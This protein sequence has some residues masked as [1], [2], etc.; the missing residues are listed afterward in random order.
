MIEEKLARSNKYSNRIRELPVVK[1]IAVDYPMLCRDSVAKKLALVAD[2]L[3]SP[4]I[5]QIDSAYRTKETEQI[6]FAN[7]K[8]VIPGL[9]NNP[10]TGVSSHNTG[11]AVD[12]ALADCTGREIN[13]SEPFN[14]YYIEPKLLSNKI[15]SEAQNLRNMLNKVM[16]EAG[17]APHPNEY[18][19]FSYGDKRWA[20]FSKNTVLYDEVD[21]NSNLYFSLWKSFFYRGL[22]ILYRIKNKLLKVETNI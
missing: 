6:L 4:Y 7:R 9:V 15:T 16:L 8:D 3:P 22:K 12:L 19:H 14:K 13:L 2:S 5:L 21:L 1:R 17:F 20:D 11:G 18:W 10:Q